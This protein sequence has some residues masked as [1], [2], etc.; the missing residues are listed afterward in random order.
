MEL[1]SR[2]GQR[3]A[4]PMKRPCEQAGKEYIAALE[5]GDPKAIAEFWTA[6]G[7]YTDENGQTFQAR[8][9]VEKSF[10]GKKHARPPMKLS[11][12]TLRFVTNDVAIEEGIYE[13]SPIE[14]PRSNRFIAVWVRQNGKWKLDTLRE[15]RLVPIAADH[16]PK[17]LAELEPLV[18]QWSGSAGKLSMYV[19][20]KWN[21]TKTFLHRELSISSDGKQVFGGLQEIGWDPGSQS[22]K[23]WAFNADG[24]HGES[25]WDLEGNSWVA[26]ASGVLPDS[27]SWLNTQLYKFTDKDTLVWKLMDGMVGG[28]PTPNMEFTLKRKAGNK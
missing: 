23:S 24:G 28:Q 16:G 27:Q 25:M 8:E 17:D 21:P 6:D 15:S 20:A 10:A 19:S 13:T 1:L 14:M 9:L 11:A 4:R 12:A 3:I 7:T 26:V 5:H 22:I 2:N 18:G